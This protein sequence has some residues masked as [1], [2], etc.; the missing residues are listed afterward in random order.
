M[1]I[2]SRLVSLVVV[3][4]VLG[5]PFLCGIIAIICN[6]IT[7]MSQ[8]RADANLKM[9]M[10]QQGYGPAEIER[11]L[12]MKTNGIKGKEELSATTWQP[13]PAKPVK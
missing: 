13:I 5:G 12:S 3:I 8:Q 9:A 1:D 11:V 10:I 6:T 4:C 2:S 7:K